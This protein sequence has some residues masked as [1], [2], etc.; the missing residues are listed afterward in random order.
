MGSL[1]KVTTLRSARQV[2]AG[3]AQAPRHGRAGRLRRRAED[4]RLGHLARLRER[5]LRPRRH[6]RRRRAWG[7][8]DAEPAHDRRRA[9]S[10]AGRRRR[11]TARRSSRCAARSTS[12]SPGF[13]RFNEAQEAAGKKPAPNPR[14]AAAGSLRQLDSRITAER[15]LSFWVYGAGAREG[16]FP[17]TQWE[18]LAWLREHGFRT[19]PH[20]RAPG[21]DRGGGRGVPGLGGAARRARLRDRRDRDQGR[22]R[23]PA[24][25]PRGAPR[26]APLGARVQ[27]GAVHGRDDAAAD[28]HPRGTHRRAQPVGTARA[29]AGRRRDRLHGDAAQRGGHQPQGHSRGRPR[30]RAARRRRDPAGGR[31]GRGAQE[32]DSPVRACPRSA[33]SA[34]STW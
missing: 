26:A 24:A 6:T 7:G 4:R 28:P 13:A 8:R 2:G 34:A 29:G 12:P 1:E 9:T 21:V 5:R 33:R 27:V 11:G 16:D 30:D 25:A 31:A 20:T 18:L 14:N 22:R 23:R 17:A 3:R 32:G 19:N 10:R 15:P